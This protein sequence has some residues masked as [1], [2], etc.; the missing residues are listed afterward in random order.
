M[1]V[2]VQSFLRAT[3]ASFHERLIARPELVGGEVHT[4]RGEQ[5]MVH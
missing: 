1:D 2:Y 5:Q 3:P 4:R